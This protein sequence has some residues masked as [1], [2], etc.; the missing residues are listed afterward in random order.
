MSFLS[1]K[2]NYCLRPLSS[3]QSINSLSYGVDKLG[4]HGYITRRVECLRFNNV[5]IFD[6][7][8]QQVPLRADERCLTISAFIR[9]EALLKLKHLIVY[10]FRVGCVTRGS[11]Y[12][13]NIFFINNSSKTSLSTNFAH[14]PSVAFE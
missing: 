4:A 11:I 3:R 9:A 13:A 6:S 14:F 5:I 1:G 10:E 8:V 2:F 12:S 7:F